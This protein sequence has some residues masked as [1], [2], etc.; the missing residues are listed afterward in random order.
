MNQLNTGISLQDKIPSQKWFNAIHIQILFFLSQQKFLV[1]S[2]SATV[3]ILS[4]GGL[5]GNFSP[6]SLT[7]LMIVQQKHSR[8]FLYL[9]QLP[10]WQ[11]LNQYLQYHH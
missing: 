1:H 3:G 11:R 8:L 5:S 10:P 4:T 2:A 6:T 7:Q 9:Q